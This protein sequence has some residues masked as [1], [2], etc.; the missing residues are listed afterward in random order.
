MNEVR[1]IVGFGNVGEDEEAGA[2]VET[3]GG[4]KVLA[5]DVVG[6]VACAAHDALLDVPR[7]WADFEHFQ[8]VIGFEDEAIGVAKME[9]DEFGEITEIRDDG[10]FSAVGAEGI[11]HGISGV[12]RNGE[13]RN[14][15]VA[16]G[17]FFAGADVFDAVE[18]FGGSHG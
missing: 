10:D 14:F 3:L 12:V 7:V 5:D 11:A 17:E 8:V 15:D 13:R 2:G 18:F 6:K 16:D 1:I 4:R 9:F